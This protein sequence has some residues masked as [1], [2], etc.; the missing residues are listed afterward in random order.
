MDFNNISIIGIGLIGSSFALALKK[1]GFKCSI[2]GIGR[3]EKNLMQAKDKGIIDNYSTVPAEGIKDADLIMLAAPPGDFE[4]I[5]RDIK[6]NIKSGAI[7]TDVG[8]VKAKIIKKIEPLMPDGVSFIGGH[9]IA[10]KESSGMDTAEPGLFRNAV[11]VITP[12]KNTNRDAMEKVLN[13]WKSVGAVTVTM[14]PDEHDLVFAAVSHLPHIAAY[15]MINA[16]F[17]IKPDILGNGGKGL[18]DMTRIALSPPGLWRDICAYNREN[19]LRA[20]KSL[21]SSISKMTELI[22]SSDWTG[23]EKEFIRAK[24]ARQ[25]IESDQH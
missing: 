12:S 13:L 11:C 23:L 18:K 6:D 25:G 14:G 5:I 7:V 8:S 4:Q 22:E 19:I 3:N 24:E 21:S 2:T 15:A 10:G 20:L 9:P 16:V 1:Q 17:D